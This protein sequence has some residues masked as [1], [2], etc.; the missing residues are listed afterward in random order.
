MS[1]AIPKLPRASRRRVLRATGAAL[2]ALPALAS[3]AQALLAGGKPV[4]L[5]VSYPAGGGADLMARLI[6]PSLSQALGT[7]VVVEN[8][9]GASGQLAAQQVAR[10]APDGSQLLLDASSFAVNPSLFPKLPYDSDKAFAPIGVLA[11]FPNVLVCTPSFAARSVRDLVR[12]AK[13]DLTIRTALL[14]SRLLV[15]DASL[16]EELQTR[17]DKEVVQGTAAE[18]LMAFLQKR[19][20]VWKAK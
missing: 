17:F 18:G 5:V 10:A 1:P 7:P 2:F 19:A 8:K 20:P 9:P 3:R 16:F 4:T 15:G 11:L 12:M 13:S 14:E 6:A